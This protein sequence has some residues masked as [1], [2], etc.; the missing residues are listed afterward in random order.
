MCE[1]SSAASESSRCVPSAAAGSVMRHGHAGIR[2]PEALTAFRPSVGSRFALAG[3][4]NELLHRTCEC[5]P[6]FGS[7]AIKPSDL[8]VVK[9]NQ[10]ALPDFPRRGASSGHILA[11][12]P[13]PPPFG[14][15]IGVP[16][17]RLFRS[18]GRLVPLQT[19]RRS[20]RSFL[21]SGLRLGCHVPR[22][23]SSPCSPRTNRSRSRRVASQPV[24][25][26]KTPCPYS[27][28]AI[29]SHRF[30]DV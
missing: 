1:S 6:V 2:A 25:G 4:R 22:C 12:E 10:H 5:E 3:V 18:D 9:L 14:I 21:S 26:R 11:P 20:G 8:V 17:T 30:A 15:F 29:V 7:A 19:T 23:H 16:R 27:S 13:Y 24:I 28:M